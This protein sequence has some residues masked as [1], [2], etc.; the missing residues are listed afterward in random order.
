MKTLE[1]LYNEVLASE[2]LKKEFL[3]L[4]P[5]K[6]EDFAA[7]HGCKASLDEIKAFFEAKKNQSGAL[8]DDELDQIAGG[9]G[10][11]GIEALNSIAT[12]GLGCALIAAISAS[13]EDMHAGVNIKGNHMLCED[14]HGGGLL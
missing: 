10:F 9:K 5:E 2:E 13:E 1:E 12:L 4:K 8:S 14:E 7:K 11:D 6:V 3:S